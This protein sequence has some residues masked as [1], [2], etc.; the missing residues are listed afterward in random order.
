[1]PFERAGPL[2]VPTHKLTEYLTYECGDSTL[3]NG[4]GLLMRSVLR[5]WILAV[6]GVSGSLLCQAQTVPV[7]DDDKIQQLLK[8]IDQLEATQKAMQDKIDGMEAAKASTPEATPVPEAASEAVA[9]QPSSGLALG[10]VEFHGFS[11]FDYGNA[12]FEKLPPGGLKSSTKSFNIGDFDL[13]TNTRLSDHWSMFGEMLVS[14]DFSN[15]FGVE[16][17]RLLLTYKRNDYFKISFGKYATSLGY[18]T[19]EFHRAQFFQTGIGRPIMYADED[20][21]GVLP[22]HNIGITA[23]G[24]IPSGGLGLHWVAEVA[25]GRSSRNPDV[26]NQNFVDEGNGK[27]VNFMAYIQPEKW[28]GFRAGFSVYHDILHPVEQ[29]QVDQT[30]FTLHAVY[31]GSKLE[32]LNEGAAVRH[33]VKD[34]SHVYYDPTFYSQVSYKFG[35][36]RPYFRYDYENVS[37]S[38][39]IFG[40]FARHNGPSVGV[41]QHLSNYVIFKAQYGR[42]FQTGQGSS[43]TVQSQLSFA[44]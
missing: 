2:T 43:N 35:K 44:F 29:P 9:D 42:L 34:V 5:I 20:N 16:M 11:D 37:S 18:Y 3:A 7:K 6:M 25:N 31:V 30:I 22:T 33:A 39:P 17:D 10:P 40:S 38:E 23:G 13:F 15:E 14:S 4:E 19:N 27:A 21:G 41:N 24:L 28:L 26:P 1:M 36:T 12:W 32:F 8:R